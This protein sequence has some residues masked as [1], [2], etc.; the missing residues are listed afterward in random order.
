MSFNDF[1]P[2]VYKICDFIDHEVKSIDEEKGGSS[3]NNGQILSLLKESILNSVKFASSDM[4]YAHFV[5][6]AEEMGSESSVLVSINELLEIYD[7]KSLLMILNS[8]GGDSYYN[9]L[10]PTNSKLFQKIAVLTGLF[11]YPKNAY[12]LCVF[13]IVNG[14]IIL[15][16]KGLIFSD[17]KSELTKLIHGNDFIPDSELRGE[18]TNIF[19]HLKNDTMESFSLMMNNNFDVV[20]LNASDDNVYYTSNAFFNKLEPPKNVFMLKERLDNKEYIK[21]SVLKIKNNRR[22]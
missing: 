14:E 1:T 4:A 20:M 11:D 18:I 17:K 10:I 2:L 9:L 3:S 22:I 19:G 21:N 16:P 6:V 8:K 15:F 7:S 5:E 12:L 13:F